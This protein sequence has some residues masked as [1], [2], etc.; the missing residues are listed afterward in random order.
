MAYGETY[1]LLEYS[2]HCMALVHVIQYNSWS[3]VMS[4]EVDVVEIKTKKIAFKH[5]A[6]EMQFIEHYSPN[7]KLRTDE[8]EFLTGPAAV[9]ELASYNLQSRRA[10][11]I[12]SD[13]GNDKYI[14]WSPEFEEFVGTELSWLNDMHDVQAEAKDIIAE[15]NLSVRTANKHKEYWMDVTLRKNLKI[16]ELE[17]RVH[18]LSMVTII[19]GGTLFGLALKLIIGV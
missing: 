15:C 9:D 12:R 14:I 7:K 5:T 1:V 8:G 10:M 19:L 2:N 13:R 16:M 4:Y 3:N 6:E 18:T 17:S 11:H